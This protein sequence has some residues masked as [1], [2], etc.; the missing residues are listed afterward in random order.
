MDGTLILADTGAGSDDSAR[1]VVRSLEGAEL[2]D[3]AS[4]E[5][6]A[7]WALTDPAFA[8]FL[9]RP[10]EERFIR[11][12]LMTNRAHGIAFSTRG[13]QAKR[14]WI[15]CTRSPAATANCSGLAHCW[16]ARRPR[17]CPCTVHGAHASQCR[18]SLV[19]RIQATR[20]AHSTVRLRRIR[21]RAVDAVATSSAIRSNTD[22]MTNA[23]LPMPAQAERT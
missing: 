9:L 6:Y 16:R 23:Q 5:A 12:C 11:G 10:E 18:S 15:Y 14:P 1:V 8:R 7:D 4:I 19:E 22:A 17:A 21:P 3:R 20:V 2:L 13:V